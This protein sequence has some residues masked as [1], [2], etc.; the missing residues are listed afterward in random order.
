MDLREY[1][2]ITRS[3]D[4]FP[5]STLLKLQ[6][7]LKRIESPHTHLIDLVLEQGYIAPP[8]EYKWHGHYRIILNDEQKALIFYELN[9][10]AGL[11][12]TS[13]LFSATE[14]ESI[15]SFKKFWERC[16]AEKPIPYEEAKRHQVYYDL[17][18]ASLAEFADWLFNHDVPA[19]S[20]NP[21][22]WHYANNIW[23]DFYEERN[24]TLFIKLFN[25][26]GALPSKFP[27][28]KLEQGMCAMQGPNLVGNVYHLIWNSDLA[29]EMKE[30]LIGS[31]YDLYA[32]LYQHTSL[33][34]SGSMWWDSLAYRF[35]VDF[36]MGE[37]RDS[38]PADKIRIQDVMFETLKRIL[39]I[40]SKACQGAALH[41]LGHLRHPATERVI[42]DYLEKHPD[43]NDE[44]RKYVMACI[45]GEIM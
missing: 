9:R 42:Q 44:D 24:V 11:G 13:A 36:D 7:A 29:I 45:T 27:L 21:D 4:T 12:T 37:Y 10:A 30:R 25:A 18:N 14:I 26:S 5:K 20:T 23:I 39:T 22:P 16:I 1:D 6:E 38:Y 19:E 2:H 43:L 17:R 28:E 33:D 8:I 35:H 40:P 34:L 3:P 32:N 41:G 15:S 31:L